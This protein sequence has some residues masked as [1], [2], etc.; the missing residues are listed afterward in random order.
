MRTKI[1][2]AMLALCAIVCFG[3]GMA[4]TRIVGNTVYG[5]NLV[6]STQPCRLLLIQGYNS[7]SAQFVMVFTNNY[8]V[9]NS[10]G[11]VYRSPVNSNGVVTIMQ[12]NGA[13]GWTSFPIGAQQYYSFPFTP[14]GVNLDACVIANSA[15]ADQYTNNGGGVTF[16]A[17]VTGQDQ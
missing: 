2:S 7:G 8:V 4:S 3:G 12:T 11:L 13:T 17:I 6:V 14:V 5:T 16:Q 1:L 15:S 9:T 10:H